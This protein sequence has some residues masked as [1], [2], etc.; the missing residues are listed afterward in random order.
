M[1][2]DNADIQKIVAFENAFD[3]LLGIADEEGGVRGNIIVQ[4][5]LQLLHNLLNYNVSNQ[6]FFRETSGVQRLP[7]LLI[8]DPSQTAAGR[9]GA[10][11]LPESEDIEWTAQHARNML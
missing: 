1:T 9:N 8:T 11:P 10:P 5:C 6:N 2:E 4:D 3:H 7:N